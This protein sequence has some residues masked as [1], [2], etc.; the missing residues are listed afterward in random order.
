MAFTARQSR[1]LGRGMAAAV[2]R[3]R[4]SGM[5][6]VDQIRAS[7]EAK[8]SS[9]KA[10]LEAARAEIERLQLRVEEL[11]GESSEHGHWVTP[12][13]ATVILGVSQATISRA[14]RGVGSG[15][16]RSKEIGGGRKASRYMVDV[17]SY[18]PANRKRRA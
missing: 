10:Q 16:I 9:L 14:A 8:T 4:D 5:E 7:F 15:F 1:A 11:E 12:K 17:N 3:S 6:T 18:R 13:D 2:D